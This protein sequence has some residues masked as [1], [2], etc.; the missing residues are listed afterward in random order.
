MSLLRKS[1]PTGVDGTLV[2][3]RDGAALTK[4]TREETTIDQCPSCKGAWFDAT[5]IKRVTRDNELAALAERVSKY[6]DPSPFPCPRCGAACVANHV[7]EVEVDTC[8]KCRGVWLDAGELEEAKR[9]IEV[10]R[11]LRDS[12]PSFRS[13]LRRV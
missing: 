9:E 2:C 1:P 12:G 11:L 4:L 6:A 3:P 8:T 10:N 7:D 13:F 5:E